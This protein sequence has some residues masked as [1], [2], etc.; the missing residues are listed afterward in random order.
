MTIGIAGKRREKSG[1]TFRRPLG[2]RPPVQRGAAVADHHRLQPGQ[3]LAAAGAA[4]ENRE[5]VLDEPPA[6]TGETLPVLLAP[7]GRESSD[8]AAVCKYDGADRWA[9]ASV[10]IA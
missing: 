3:P 9:V 8:L 4:T 1:V 7:V 2:S 5:L 10:G 6:T